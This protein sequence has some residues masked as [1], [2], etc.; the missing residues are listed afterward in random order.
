M[1]CRNRAGQGV[2][3]IMR[4]SVV[5]G[6]WPRLGGRSRLNANERSYCEAGWSCARKISRRRVITTRYLRNFYQLHMQ[7]VLIRIRIGKISSTLHFARCTL[8]MLG[9]SQDNGSQT[10]QYERCK[11]CVRMNRICSRQ[12]ILR[13]V[14]NM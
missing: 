8:G 12:I 14:I 2:D 10:Q 11:L 5:R 13:F 4:S 9:N 6:H 3:C 7:P 1:Y